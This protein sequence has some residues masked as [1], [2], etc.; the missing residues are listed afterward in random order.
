MMRL[1]ATALVALLL[2]GCAEPR[3]KPASFVEALRRERE[4]A[5]KDPAAYRLPHRSGGDGCPFCSEP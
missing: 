5:A 4:R 3:P 2:A 1:A